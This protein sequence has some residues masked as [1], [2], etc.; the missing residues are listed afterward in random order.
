M[1][2]KARGEVNMHLL[3]SRFRVRVQAFTLRKRLIAILVAV[4]I[5]SISTFA[6][7]IFNNQQG[8][9]IGSLFFRK[10][11]ENR[12]ETSA[13]NNPAIKSEVTIELDE[14]YRVKWDGYEWYGIMVPDGFTDKDGNVIPDEQMPFWQRIQS[15]SQHGKESHKYY[16]KAKLDTM[17]A[18]EFETLG[19]DDLSPYFWFFGLF[20]LVLIYLFPNAGNRLHGII[21]SEYSEPLNEEERQQK[22]FDVFITGIILVACSVI[23]V[24]QTIISNWV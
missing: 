1:D 15:I 4:A 11:A 6:L 2:S 16:F 12:Y 14:G 7:W 21:Y 20:F 8:V 22:R 24:A 23:Y 9:W 5:L 10:V 3:W 17:R 19:H 18:G 13:L